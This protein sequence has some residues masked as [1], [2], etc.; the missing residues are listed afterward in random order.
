MIFSAMAIAGS[1]GSCWTESFNVQP[2]CHLVQRSTTRYAGRMAT[3]R[4]TLDEQESQLW[5][6]VIDGSQLLRT[7]IEREVQR[8]A[9]VPAGYYGILV[10]LS[11][12]RGRRMR[13]GDLA[14]A[15]L[16]SPSRLSHAVDKLE[17]AGWVER[18]A[19]GGDGRG[20]DA[21]LTDAGLDA[22][23]SAVPVAASA[24]REHF[25]DVMDDDERA[26]VGAVFARV[27]DRLRAD[28]VACPRLGDGDGDGDACCG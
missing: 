2:A 1:F 8:S 11:E 7:R 21:V 15:T 25:L 4:P 13:M 14:T 27:R 19:C 22:L 20:L 10:A 28:L 16:S 24:V 26:V 9:T 23:R 12:A 3:P 6:A 18:R 17:A 5:R